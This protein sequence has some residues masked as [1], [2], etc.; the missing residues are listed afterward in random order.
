MLWEMGHAEPISQAPSTVNNVPPPVTGDDTLEMEE[1]K[2]RKR[3]GVG[4]MSTPTLY[5]LPSPV[6]ITSGSPHDPAP[7]ETPQLK[8]ADNGED[9]DSD[10]EGLMELIEGESKQQIEQW[11]A[12]NYRVCQK[13]SARK[14]RMKTVENDQKIFNESHPGHVPDRL[15]MVIIRQHPE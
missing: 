15:G 7:E 9:T 13:R 3:Q 4:K 2:H 10:N 14:S 8:F 1:T 12:H 11:K 5:T 6:T